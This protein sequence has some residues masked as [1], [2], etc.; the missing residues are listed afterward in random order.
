MQNNAM[1]ASAMGANNTAVSGNIIW[2]KAYPEGLSWDVD[3][4]VA[5]VFDILD[6]SVKQFAARP[7]I[8]FEGMSMTYAELGALVNKVAAGL[9][10]MGVGKGTKIGLFMPNTHYSVAFYYGVLKTGA[11]VVNYNPLYVERELEYQIGDSETDYMVTLD[12]P[13][14]FDKADHV[15]GSTRLKGIILCPSGA[16]DAATPSG[17]EYIAYSDIIDNYGV[18]AAPV[19]NPQ[20][21]VAVLQYTGGTTGTPKGAMLTHANLFANTTQI[22]MWH[23]PI[24]VP[25]QERIIGAIPLFHVFSMTVVMN[26]ALKMGMEVILVPKFDPEAF[27]ALLK[28]KK[29][30]FFPA[31][32]TIFNALAVHPAGE[33]LDLSFVKFCLS[34]GAPLPQGI[35]DAFEKRTGAKL[36]E[37]YGLTEASPV[38]CCN[39]TNGLVKVGT[40]GMPIPGTLVEIIDMEDGVTPLAQGEKGEVCLKGQQVMKGYY[41]KPEETNKVIKNGRLH[42]GDVGYI[43]EDGYIRLVDRMKDLILVRG[44]NVY[45]TQIEGAISLHVDVEECIVAG[46]PDDE[47]G[48]TVWAWVKARDGSEL[49]EAALKTFLADKI[50]PIE[51]PRKIVLRDTPLPKTAVGKLSRKLLLEEE[52]IER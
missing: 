38:V 23:S 22:E 5:P 45:P 14:L 44:Y 34:G 43:D 30:T 18:Y 1:A 33:G 26:M 10:K 15:L 47:R 52:G 17:D 24:V 19:I 4:A 39:P 27:I 49:S 2:N 6:E 7:A 51:M 8:Y 20:E 40:I 21:D 50:S 3:V 25:G 41:N 31:V 29:P 46:V 37:G 9:Q 35:K 36:G 48:E 42:T 28:D 11:T 32:P 13:A 16:A 12:M